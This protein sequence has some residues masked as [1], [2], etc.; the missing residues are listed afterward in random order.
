MI[1]ASG[2]NRKIPRDVRGLCQR[3]AE[4][5]HR[6]WVVGGCVRDE[7]LAEPG[8]AGSG[9]AT[10]LER[11]DWDIATDARP[12]QV[13]RLFRRVIP[14]GIEHGTVTVMLREVGY[15]VTTLRGETTYSDGRRPDAVYF[16]DDIVADLARRD[17][18]INAIAYDPLA[19]QLID[20]FGGIRDLE[21]RVLRAV[22]DPAARFAEDGLRV[23]RGARFRAV[24]EV[25][26]EPS[27]LAAIR[28]SLA[29]YR[30]VSPERIREEWLKTMRAARP[31]RAFEV[32]REHGML[33]ITAPELMETVG[34]E[35]NRFHA[36]DVWGHTMACLDECPRDPV[37]RVG[38]LLH[39]VGKPR[40]RG[41]SERTGDYT[42]YEH[43]RIGAEMAEPLLTRLRF[44]ND[45][46]ARIVALVRHHLI[47]YDESW[48]D[49][50]VRRWVRR[51]TPE[52]LDDL[53]LLNRA[54]VIAK[55]TGADDDLARSRELHERALGLMAAGAALTVRDLAL[56]GRV[57]MSELGLAPGPVLGE[58]LRALLEA[59]TE[60]PEL[61]TRERLVERARALISESA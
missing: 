43:E 24:L 59:V 18:T 41:Q 14:T 12:E 16:V 40:S 34:C 21:A 4:A 54:D 33:E 50:A 35:Q 51:V 13:T 20:P 6:A 1:D 8:A 7:L 60:E 49:A 28:P 9:R 31:S 26:F 22:G 48:S 29:S 23:L 25:E 55:G 30:K 37:L 19:D 45:E 46:R 38:G 44:S 61:N 56:D 3:L 57:L 36:Y 58:L 2:L 42:F 32:M 5:G 39:D 17:F 52:L 10:P 15:E 11:H 47:V 27:T 53:F